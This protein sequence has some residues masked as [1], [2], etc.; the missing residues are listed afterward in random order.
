M[1]RCTRRVGV[2]AFSSRLHG[3]ELVPAKWR[4]LVSPTSGYRKPLGGAELSDLCKWKLNV[5]RL[6]WLIILVTTACSVS[7]DKQSILDKSSCA[8]P[9]WNGIIPGQ[10]TEADLLEILKTLP[11][12]D[13]D[14]IQIQNRQGDIFDRLIFF[15][16]RQE[17]TLSQRP[18]LHGQASIINNTVS[19]FTIC[20][21]INTSM[22]QLVEGIGEP[23]YIISGNN[24]GGGRTVILTNSQKGFSFSFTTELDN[25]KITPITPIDCIDIF[26]PSLY[27][28]MLD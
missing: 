23:E 21:A 15:S 19:V 27:E 1:R 9:C 3:L 24:I 18:S 11:D 8:L 26:D 16:F 7:A 28:K 2:C 4:C 5:K 12:I 17:W 22:D 6:I 14:A 13:T 25:L 20:G 10:T